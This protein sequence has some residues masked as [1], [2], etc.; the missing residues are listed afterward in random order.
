[1]KFE[2]KFEKV[3]LIFQSIVDVMI[4]SVSHLP[5][6]EHLL[7]VAI[8]N[9]EI[10]YIT[11]VCLDINNVVEELLVNAKMRI[12]NVIEKNRPGPER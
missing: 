11:T 1:M 7:F 3:K 9:L 5:R 12:K 2:P 8:E 10:K 6:V 4:E